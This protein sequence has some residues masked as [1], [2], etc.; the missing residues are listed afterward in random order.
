LR[1]LES[2]SKVSSKKR[3]IL[4]TKLKWKK[5]HI[6]RERV[7]VVNILDLILIKKRAMMEVVELRVVEEANKSMLLKISSQI[8]RTSQKSKLRIL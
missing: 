5:G 7:V 8:R 2:K 1:S 4:G 6:L 3:Q